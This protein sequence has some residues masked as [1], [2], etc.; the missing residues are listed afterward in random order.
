MQ[1]EYL[2]DIRVLF[3]TVFVFNIFVTLL[4]NRKLR[5]PWQHLLAISNLTQTALVETYNIR[6]CE[7]STLELLNSPFAT[8]HK[9]GI[10]SKSFSPILQIEKKT[11]L[12][13]MKVTVELYDI[14]IIVKVN[15]K[16]V[17]VVTPLV[18]CVCFCFI[19]Y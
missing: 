1:V 18:Q 9:K 6:V 17:F 7:P 3:K 15:V 11:N 4:F 19:F 8:S 10:F 2:S 14:P 5:Y 16:S 12:M 13:V